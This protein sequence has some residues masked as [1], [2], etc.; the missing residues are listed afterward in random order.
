MKDWMNAWLL[1]SSKPDLFEPGEALFWNDPHISR[2]MLAAHLDETTDLA[3]RRSAIIDSTV[4]FWLSCGLLKPQMQLLDLGCGPGLYATRLARAGLQV[5]AVDLSERSLAYARTQAEREHLKIDYQWMD[6]LDLDACEKFDAVLQVYGELNT[7]SNEKRDSLLAKVWQALKPGG[8]FLFDLST[9]VLRKRYG[10]KNSWYA[11]DGGFWRPGRHFLLE[12]GYS[13]PE[14]SVWLDQYVVIDEQGICVYRNWF[15]DYD[16]PTV[17]DFLA[18]VGFR[19]RHV[20][21]DL[22]GSPYSEDSDWI[23]VCAEKA[24]T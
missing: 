17:E 8:I 23:A 24:C 12:N 20:W 3:S 10:L 5:T 21:G 9:P 1:I 14:T 19:L 13:Y 15:H 22:A 16:L 4:V 7:F 6:F 2:G 18:E 11:V